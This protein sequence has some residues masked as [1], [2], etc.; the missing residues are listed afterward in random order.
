MPIY[1]VFID[2]EEMDSDEVFHTEEEAEAYGLECLGNMRVGAEIFH[3]SNP[4][5][6]DFDENYYD[7]LDFEIIEV[8]D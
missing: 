1:K 8:D 5:D 4:G 7:N 6:Y 3:M 2:G